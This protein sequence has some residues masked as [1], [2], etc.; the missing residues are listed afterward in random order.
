MRALNVRT[1]LQASSA[2]GVLAWLAWLGQDSWQLLLSLETEAN[3]A[4]PVTTAL[5][6]ETPDPVAIA[7][8]FGVAP[9]D[10]SDSI[11]EV[12]LR[13]LASLVESQA[14]Q[15]RALIASPEDSRFYRIGETLP[16]GGILR[17]VGINHVLVQRLGT[18]QILPMDTSS[19]ALLTPI[20]E[21]DALR[22]ITASRPAAE[23]LVKPSL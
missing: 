12:P 17:Q 21:T 22:P 11:P 13:L 18:E 9:Q 6:R 19:A 4:P 2:L 5:P 10:S 15:S 16:G 8:L 20:F 1:L 7:Q 3:I 23:R 14:E